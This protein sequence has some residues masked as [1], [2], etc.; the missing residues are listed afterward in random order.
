MFTTDGTL[1]LVFDVKFFKNWLFLSR[2]WLNYS[3]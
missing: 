3:I 2:Q 1:P